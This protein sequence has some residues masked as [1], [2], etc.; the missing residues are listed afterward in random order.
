MASTPKPASTQ[1]HL[2]I[3]Q[4]RDSLVVMKDGT[5]RAV[6]LVSAVNFAL[7]SQQEQD[8]IIYQFQSFING[9]THPLQ[10]V[11]QSRQ[12]DLNR[13]LLHMADLAQNQSNELLRF[14]MVDYIDF[15][16]R[17]VTLANIME[18]RFYVVIPHY[19]VQTGG[20]GLLDMLT[21]GRKTVPHYSQ[22][23]FNHYK[24]EITERVNVVVS[25]L[26]S[27]GLRAVQLNTQELV[28]FYYSIYNP[29]EATEE[30][31]ID[32]EELHASI[33]QRKPGGS[34]AV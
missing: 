10:I 7:K 21:G 2:S 29:E 3:A 20:H 31:L 11:V 1:K 8:A 22:E 5:F 23:Q 26:S 9:M 15:V 14:Q 16:S 27:I 12:L 4:V 24:Q 30:K 25:G 33:I 6:L 19:T 17:L 32:I 28:E 18:K 13:Y 34:H